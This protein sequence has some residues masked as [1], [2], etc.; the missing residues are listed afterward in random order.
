M[1]GFLAKPLRFAD[2]EQVL[3]RWVPCVAGVGADPGVGEA[4]GA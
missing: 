4:A 2:L 1:N 3:A